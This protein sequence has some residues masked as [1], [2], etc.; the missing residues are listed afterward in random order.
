[1]KKET[2]L[3]RLVTKK[4][5]AVEV[6]LMIPLFVL[7]VFVGFVNVVMRYVFEKGIY[8]AEEVFTFLFV[9]AIFIGFSTALK[10]GSHVE[11][12]LVYNYL[13]RWLQRITD[14][15]SSLVGIG[16]CLFFTYYGFHAV[17]QQYNLGGVTMDARIPM[18]L[19]SLI[20]PASGI[21]LGIS[22]IYRI[23]RSE[24]KH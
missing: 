2:W 5:T 15:I 4:I 18:W 17:T 3:D 12:T 1:M 14:V 24:S 23:Y 22:F 13:P 19:V 9:W 8:G 16:F 21:L 11:V 10:D 20:L 7:A 6:A